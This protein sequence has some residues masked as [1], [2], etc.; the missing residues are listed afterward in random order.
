[1][2][3][4]A[5]SILTA[6]FAHLSKEIH[7]LEEGKPAMLHLDVMDGHF[8]PNITF[9]PSLVEAIKPLTSSELDVHLMVQEPDKWIEPFV[10]A[11]ADYL[12]VHA[13]VA[14]HLHRTIQSIKSFGV[15]AGV[16]INPATSLEQIRYVLE[17]VD[18]VLI[19]T[20]NPGF[21]GQAFIPQML[22]KIK[23]LKGLIHQLGRDI[24]IEVDGGINATTIQSVQ[25]A[26]AEWMVVGSAIFGETNYVRAM[27]ALEALA[28]GTG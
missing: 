19:M 2:V 17:H 26:G 12:S 4:I 7:A 13:E 10:R 16:A 8:V 28:N 1:M 6:N 21:G 23:A 24:P 11:G 3:R 15:K 9:G 20:V 14:P 25:E 22:G 5:P 18:Y 27:K